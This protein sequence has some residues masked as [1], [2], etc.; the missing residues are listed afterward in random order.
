M[1]TTVSVISEVCGRLFLCA[2]RKNAK[3]ETNTSFTVI[4]VISWDCLCLRDFQIQLV[5]L[6]GVSNIIIIVPIF[7][8]PEV[9]DVIYRYQCLRLPHQNQKPKKTNLLQG[10]GLWPIILALKSLT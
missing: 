2:A 3:S 8:P 5:P 7:N 10:R 9:Y 4:R 1:R 6:K